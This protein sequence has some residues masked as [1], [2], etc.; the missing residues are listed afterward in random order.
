MW[1]GGGWGEL[2][3]KIQ[4][5]LCSTSVREGARVYFN[6]ESKQRKS[7]VIFLEVFEGLHC[8][9]KQQ[10]SQKLH[11][12]QYPEIDIHRAR[13]WVTV[14]H[15]LGHALENVQSTMSQ[16]TLIENSEIFEKKKE[17]YRFSLSFLQILNKMDSNIVANAITLITAERYDCISAIFH[18]ILNYICR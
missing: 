15:A 5:E 1:G 6:V 16:I 10:D 7:S 14:I 4:I 3:E 12:G 18:C 9:E 11:S 13:V 17:K 8:E 2:I